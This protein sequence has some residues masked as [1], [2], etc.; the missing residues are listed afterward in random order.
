MCIVISVSLTVNIHQRQKGY[1]VCN[2]KYE[3]FICMKR[4]E[5]NRLCLLQ[6]VFVVTEIG[7]RWPNFLG[8]YNGIYKVMDLQLA[9]LQNTMTI[10]WWMIMCWRLDVIS[11]FLEKLTYSYTNFLGINYRLDLIFPKRVWHLVYS[12]SNMF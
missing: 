5:Y 7:E 1:Y 8:C 12:F 11:S 4:I 6:G 2:P 9:Q 10:V 3:N